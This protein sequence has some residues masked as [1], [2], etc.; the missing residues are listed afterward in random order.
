MR[1][2]SAESQQG[3]AGQRALAGQLGRLRRKSRRPVLIVADQPEPSAAPPE[4]DARQR[5]RHQV[6]G[7]AWLAVIPAGIVAVVLTLHAVSGSHQTV[8][9]PRVVVASLPY[10][11]LSQG[12][13]AVLANRQAVSE[14][15]PWIYGLAG[16]GHVVLDSGISEPALS[17]SLS[18]LRARGLPLVPTIAN[19]NA[20]GNWAYPPV[21]RI[22][23]DP[24]LMA[25]HVAAIVALADSGHYAGIDIDYEDLQPATGRTSPPSLPGWPPR[26]TPRGRSCRSRCSPR[27]PT[28]GTRRATWR[29]TTRPSARSPTRCG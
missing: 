5:R 9:A 22:L 28:P 20:H 4:T 6:T 24:V 12:T 27:P 10:W 29:R 14:V 26:C 19:V 18:Q 1:A 3:W 11:N 15:S 17:R 23:H 2:E 21:A 8:P 16:D 25:R 7:S 13:A